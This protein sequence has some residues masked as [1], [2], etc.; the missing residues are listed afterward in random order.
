MSLFPVPVMIFFCLPSY[1]RMKLKPRKRL[2]FGVDGVDELLLVCAP[3]DCIEDCDR[4][5][6]AATFSP[7]VLAL[8]VDEERRRVSFKTW[9]RVTEDVEAV[10]E[11]KMGAERGC[12]SRCSVNLDMLTVCSLLF[13]MIDGGMWRDCGAGELWSGRERQSG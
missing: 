12:S 7:L 9:S 3:V 2:F 6:A 11:A 5:A 8:E 1:L 10:A 13:C 4:E